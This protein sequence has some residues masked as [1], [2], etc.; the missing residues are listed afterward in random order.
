MTR[1]RLEHLLRFWQRTLRLQDWDIELE[2]VPFEELG[3]LGIC[4]TILHAGVVRIKLAPDH[5]ENGTEALLEET[6]IHELLEIYLRTFYKGKSEDK[7]RFLN[8][9]S[10]VLQQ[11]ATEAG[12]E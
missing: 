2:T 4:S 6:L 1:T 9:L 12:Y 11:L 5:S 10:R 7:E 8:R 3:S